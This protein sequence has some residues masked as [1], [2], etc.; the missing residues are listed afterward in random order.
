MTVIHFHNSGFALI[1][2]IF[3][4]I[5]T[6]SLKGFKHLFPDDVEE[7]EFSVKGLM[8]VRFVPLVRDGK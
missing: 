5:C 2:V 6:G 1:L 7:N 8:H 4:C 3:I